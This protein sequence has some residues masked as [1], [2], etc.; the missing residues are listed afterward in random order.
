VV[1]FARRLGRSQKVKLK[2]N[3]DPVRHPAY[4]QRYETHSGA[5]PKKAGRGLSI[6]CEDGL[7]GGSAALTVVGVVD[8]SVLTIGNTA[9]RK[10][11]PTHACEQH[12]S[13][14]TRL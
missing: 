13:E 14:K 6:A 8:N 11:R 12:C 4:G 7:G 1:E 10:S 2:V 5:S 3:T 9:E